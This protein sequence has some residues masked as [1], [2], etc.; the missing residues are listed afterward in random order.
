MQVENE[1]TERAETDAYFEEIE[2]VMVEEGIVSSSLG[3]RVAWADGVG[4]S[5]VVPLTFNGWGM[6]YDFAS[7]KA[8]PDLCSSLL[9]P[10]TS[11]IPR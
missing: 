9:F 10:L 3:S 4:F 6:T 1:L 11:Y 2:R 5:Q 8:E 7:G